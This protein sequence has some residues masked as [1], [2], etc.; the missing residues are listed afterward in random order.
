MSQQRKNQSTRNTKGATDSLCKKLKE[1]QLQGKWVSKEEYDIAMCCDW[2]VIETLYYHIEINLKVQCIDLLI[3]IMFSLIYRLEDMLECGH[4]AK[5]FKLTLQ[6]TG[7]LA[8]HVY[9]Q[10]FW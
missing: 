3:L 6:G 1:A 2:K 10:F 8:T 9:D 7:R 4:M 5:I